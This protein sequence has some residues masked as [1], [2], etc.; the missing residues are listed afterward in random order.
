[1]RKTLIRVLSELVFAGDLLKLTDHPKFRKEVEKTKRKKKNEEILQKEKEKE[2][3]IKNAPFDQ[4]T[5]KT[6][7]EKKIFDKISEIKVEKIDD[8]AL[9]EFLQ[10]YE[11]D[12]DEYSS[13]SLMIKK[14]L[15]DLAASD[16]KDAGALD[17]DNCDDDSL[18]TIKSILERLKTYTPAERKKDSNDLLKNVEVWIDPIDNIS[19]YIPWEELYADKVDGFEFEV[20]YDKNGRRY[21]ESRLTEDVG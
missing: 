11:D 1:M 4:P 16:L 7:Y 21:K 9:F 2:L 5:P 14:Y 3:K 17:L 12:D 20:G 15:L 6:P 10:K 8:D 13:Y 18:K 19:N